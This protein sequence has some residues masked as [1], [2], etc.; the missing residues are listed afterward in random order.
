MARNADGIFEEVFAS[1]GD[2]A[3][4]PFTIPE[5]FTSL[6]SVPVSAGGSAPKRLSFNYVFNQLYALGVDVNKFGGA[7]PW[8]ATINYEIGA[9]VVASDNNLYKAN[10]ANINVDPVTALTEWS[11]FITRS[12]ILSLVNNRRII[13]AVNINTL[14]SD[15][16]SF[17]N[18]L[19]FVSG[20]N[21]VDGEDPSGPILTFSVEIK[22][23]TQT[24]SIS[25]TADAITDGF[26]SGA[27]GVDI[28]T[29]VSNFVLRTRMA[30]IE[31]DTEAKGD[32][33]S[34]NPLNNF[35]HS[36]RLLV[37]DKIEASLP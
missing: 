32:D 37:F 33:V 20:I 4:P 2:K 19:N 34:F 30:R 22:G 1:T 11:D 8:A 7:L 23:G 10:A 5:G 35:I 27:V 31:V 6:Y 25:S 14:T 18:G 29:D 12:E 9:M 16:F 26:N 21:P 13:A 36:H 15:S 28:S 17:T 3:V 24:Y